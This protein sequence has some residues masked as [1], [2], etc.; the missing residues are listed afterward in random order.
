MPVYVPTVSMEF[1][2]SAITDEL[3]ARFPGENREAAARELRL[4]VNRA[5]VAAVRKVL[6]RNLEAAIEENLAILRDPSSQWIGHA[7]CA[8]VRLG[9]TE[10]IPWLESLSADPR[11]VQYST[12]MAECIQ[13]ERRLPITRERSAA[14]REALH[15]PERDQAWFDAHHGG[16]GGFTEPL[17]ALAARSARQLRELALPQK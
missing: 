8:L 3:L 14:L 16:H 7:I 17:G 12:P 2:A 6:G 10:A 11:E 15:D 1:L 5:S 13:P 9:A 4:A